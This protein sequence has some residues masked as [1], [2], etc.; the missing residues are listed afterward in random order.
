MIFMFFMPFLT[1]SCVWSIG[2]YCFY[3]PG[4]SS[5]WY[6]CF[7]PSDFM[8]YFSFLDRRWLLDYFQSWL[9]LQGLSG[10]YSGFFPLPFFGIMFIFFFFYFSFETNLEL[11]CF[12]S[13]H[14]WPSIW[15]LNDVFSC[16]LVS[17]FL[18]E[19]ISDQYGSMPDFSILLTY[20]V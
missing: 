4:G 18:L 12:F 10:E 7:F 19:F 20:L 15:Y 11:C 5:C 2:G 8:F 6:Y 13:R 16:P 3:F 14:G 17:I 9:W 1:F